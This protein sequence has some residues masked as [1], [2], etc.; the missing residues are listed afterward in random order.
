MS[1]GLAKEHSYAI[2]ALLREA[3]KVLMEAGIEDAARDV[4]LIM[5]YVLGVTQEAIVAGRVVDISDDEACYFMQLIQRRAQNE[6]VAK[7]IGSKAFWKDT[8]LTTKDTLDPRPDTEIIIE[9]ITQKYEDRFAPLRFLDLGTGTGCVLLSLLREYPFARGVGVDKSDAAVQVAQR[10]A[11]TLRLVN[12]TDILLSDWTQQVEGQFDIIVSNPPYISQSDYEILP[13]DVKHYDPK[14]ALVAGDD[15]LEAYRQL[16]PLA[17]DKLVDGGW[18]LLEVGVG[19]AQQVGAIG[20]VAGLQLD[21]V[22][23]DLAGIERVVVLRR[24]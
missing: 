16:I 24:S 21:S 8:F 3:R 19:Q 15:G 5:Q 2:D 1:V 12:R 11:R 14:S 23:T 6:P 10:N 7:I 20:V 18:L 13:S 22:Q 4:R 9:T 17:V